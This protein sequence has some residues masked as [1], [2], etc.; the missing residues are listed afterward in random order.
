MQSMRHH[1][2]QFMEQIE[3]LKDK[4]D[5]GYNNRNA[6]MKLLP[7]LINIDKRD[8]S[9]RGYLMMDNNPDEFYEKPYQFLF[10]KGLRK[11]ALK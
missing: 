2:C 6:G 5:F 7:E 4:K 9:T 10:S 3:R 1:H 8:G 11:E